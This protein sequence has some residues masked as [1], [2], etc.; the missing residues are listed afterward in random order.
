MSDS[1]FIEVLLPK[2]KDPSVKLAY[3]ASQIINE[4]DEVVGD[5][6]QTEYLKS[7]SAD[8][9]SRS[10]CIPA[11]QEVSDVLGIKNTIVNMSAVLFRRFVLT[12]EFV[13]ELRRMEIGGDYFFCLNAILG[14]KIFYVAELLNYNRRHPNSIVV[15][16]LSN[17]SDKN[18]H[19][20][21]KDFYINRSFVAKTYPLAPDF[22]S[23]LDGYLHILWETLAPDRPYEELSRYLPLEEMMKEVERNIH[24]T[25]MSQ[26]SKVV[27]RQDRRV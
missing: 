12:P 10:Y 14:G 13:D 15:N 21:F 5:Y 8:R 19:K 1:R 11:E 25:K 26:T 24:N 7:L 27:S 3:S 9:W 6:R 23:K 2:F 18:L 17:R 22:Y 4:E 20:Y 16:A